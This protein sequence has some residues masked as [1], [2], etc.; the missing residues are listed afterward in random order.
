MVSRNLEA[1]RLVCT[2]C[3]K[4][5]RHLGSNDAEA[6]VKFQSDAIIRIIN[7]AASELCFT[8]RRLIGNWNGAD[9]A[10]TTKL[11]THFVTF[12]FINSGIFSDAIIPAGRGDLVKCRLG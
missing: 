4:F 9:T 12:L 3:L 8:I 5:G 2:I 10:M 11:D 1:T 7:L 6:P